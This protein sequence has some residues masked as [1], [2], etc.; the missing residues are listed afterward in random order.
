MITMNLENKTIL[1]TGGS[2]GIG[3]ATAIACAQAGARVVIL[4]RDESNLEK[5]INLMEGTGHLYKVFD[6]NN[7]Y[8]YD[9]LFREI[10]GEVGKLDG[11][12]HS[13]GV[14]AV[15]PLKVLS[16]EKMLEVMNVNY[17][18]FIGL[19]K[20]YSKKGNS[21]GGSIVGISS[22]VVERGEQCQTIYAATKAAMEASVKCLAIELAPKNIRINTVMPG[23]I[24]TEMMER[25]L[26][27][28]S[29]GNVLGSASVLGI[30]QPEQ[31]ANSVIFLL[32]ELSSH[33]TGRA[34]YVDGGCL[35]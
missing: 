12:V 13:A 23:M 34:V 5:T 24:R 4:G 18:S 14:S 7:R 35:L 1:I 17:F 27:N 9:N 19:V 22:I 33:T 32:S 26:D 3:R 30:G 2:S 16:R 29:Q 20:E 31:V 21:N 25:V 11:L 15:I 6:F 8:D 28:G 10:V